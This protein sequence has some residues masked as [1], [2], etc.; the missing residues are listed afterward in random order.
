M[1]N[2]QGAMDTSAVPICSLLL[3]EGGS[4]L[5]SRL[6]PPP[7]S[8][9]PQPS[10]WALPCLAL[11]TCPVRLALCVEQLL[12]RPDCGCMCHR[13]GQRD[14]LPLRNVWQISHSARWPFSWMQNTLR[15]AVA[16]PWLPETGNKRNKAHICLWYGGF[17]HA[18]CHVGDL[19]M[20]A[21]LLPRRVGWWVEMRAEWRTEERHPLSGWTED[22]VQR[23]SGW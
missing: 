20:L 11:H 15:A 2:G 21:E 4:R 14:C 22:T 3:E 17:H 18:A 19:Q 9:C 12:R 5:L 6:P 16:L 10:L 1:L 23:S 8:L 13:G 7:V